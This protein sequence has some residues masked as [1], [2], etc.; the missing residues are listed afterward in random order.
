VC[1]SV[2]LEIIAHHLHV[3]GRTRLDNYREREREGGRER[4]REG[5]NGIYSD[6]LRVS[7][8]KFSK[9][10][11][12][13]KKILKAISC[14]FFCKSSISYILLFPCSTKQI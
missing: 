1:K 11:N 14:V 2:L 8:G 10:A 13:E 4:G 9:T 5:E 6:V 12:A 3:C 7:A